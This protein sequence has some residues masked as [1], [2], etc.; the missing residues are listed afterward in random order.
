MNDS[1]IKSKLRQDTP[2]KYSIG[3]GLYLRISN[4]CIGFFAVRYTID[5]NRREITPG[6]YGKLADGMTL[7]V[8]KI[9]ATKIRDQVKK[10]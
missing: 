2:G 8:T 9:E 3:D 1:Q 10:H 6:K 4:E 7:S 5:I